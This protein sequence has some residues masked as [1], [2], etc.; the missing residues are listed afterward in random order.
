MSHPGWR[1]AGWLLV[2]LAFGFSILAIMTIGLAILP[3]AVVGAWLMARNAGS[4]GVGAVLCG[5]GLGP[6]YVALLNRNGPG[7]VCHTY[8]DGSGSCTQEY[9]PWPF[10]AVAVVLIVCGAW[11]GASSLRR[12]SR[13]QL[14]EQ[15][16]SL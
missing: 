12:T 7:D 15:D 10:V 1:F 6:A 13:A 11:W 5:L 16:Q 14:T 8:S 9:S 3:F 2:G 4:G